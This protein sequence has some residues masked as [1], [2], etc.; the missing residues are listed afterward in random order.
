MGIPKNLE[1]IKRILCLAQ[2][3]VCEQR[4]LL[5]FLSRF[6]ALPDQSIYLEP[7][8]LTGSGDLCCY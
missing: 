8:F 1:T 3:F 5:N 4:Q 6:A 7:Y 2:R